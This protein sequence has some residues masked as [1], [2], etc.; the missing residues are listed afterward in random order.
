M[1]DETVKI[2]AA[3][4]KETTLA[5]LYETD[6]G[7]VWIPKSQIVDGDDEMVEV[8]RWFA[9]ERGLIDEDDEL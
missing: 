1:S 8:E 4:M 6:A 3:L 9:E 2:K 5:G 7:E